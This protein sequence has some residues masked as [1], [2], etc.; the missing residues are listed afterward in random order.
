MRE[1][2]GRHRCRTQ[3]CQWKEE[4]EGHKPLSLRP[5]HGYL[6]LKEEIP[7]L[8][9]KTKL[10][11]ISVGQRERPWDKVGVAVLQRGR[12]AVIARLEARPK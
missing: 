7:F 1:R 4:G 11:R 8:K 6:S 2:I 3:D 5:L 12:L 9:K 10:Y